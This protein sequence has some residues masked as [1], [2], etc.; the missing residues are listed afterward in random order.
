MKNRKSN[1]A[2]KNTIKEKAGWVGV[3]PTQQTSKSILLLF[4]SYNYP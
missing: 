4:A 3:L 1:S 2:G